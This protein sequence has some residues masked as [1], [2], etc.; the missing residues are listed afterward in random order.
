MNNQKPDPPSIG[1]SCEGKYQW[2]IDNHLIVKGTNDCIEFDRIDLETG[3]PT[4]RKQSRRNV[5]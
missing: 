5:H 4:V 3:R 2:V 1:K